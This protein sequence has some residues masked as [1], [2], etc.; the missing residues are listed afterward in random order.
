MDDLESRVALLK[1]AIA[2]ADPRK[3]PDWRFEREVD[4]LVD[5]FY[6][7]IGTIVRLPLKS[8]FDLFLIKVM[9]V[10]RGAREPAVL[11][12]LS[13]MLTRFLLTR[14]LMG[15]NQARFDLLLTILD[16]MNERRRFQNLFEASRSMGDSALFLTGVFPETRPGRRRRRFGTARP[17]RIDKAHFIDAGRRYYRVAAEEELAAVVGQRDV[18]VRLADHFPFWVETLSEMSQRYILGFDLEVVANKML[19]AFN[20]YRETGAQEHLEAAGKYAALLKVDRSF[21][22]LGR[23]RARIIDLGNLA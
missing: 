21:A 8:L 5:A 7:D 16:E 6:D 9:Y 11:D 3:A 10:G 2:I 18:L 23:P 12:Y 17:V 19:D 20:R 15:L 14:E 22:G 1:S 13:D 4:D